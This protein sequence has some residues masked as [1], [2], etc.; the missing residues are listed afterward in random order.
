MPSAS[1]PCAMT[2]SSDLHC[3]AFSRNPASS[4]MARSTSTSPKSESAIMMVPRLVRVTGQSLRGDDV[5]VGDGELEATAG[6]HLS[7]VGAEQLLP[8][9]LVVQRRLGVVAPAL[10]D[11]LVRELHVEA[12]IGNV[13]ADAVAGA[14]DREVPADRRLGTD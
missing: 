14:Q 10:G 6:V 12:V 7:G 4:T 5:L 3:W 1:L 8:R 2:S 13:E 11:L 9:R